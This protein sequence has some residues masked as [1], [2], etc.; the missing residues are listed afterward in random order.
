MVINAYKINDIIEKQNKCGINK[1]KKGIE[2]CWGISEYGSREYRI[3]YDLTNFVVQS[4]DYQFTYMCLQPKMSNLPIKNLNIKS[5][6]K[7][8]SKE[9]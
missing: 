3:T 6:I 7:N 8:K 1:T 4:N 9:I 5:I 2:L